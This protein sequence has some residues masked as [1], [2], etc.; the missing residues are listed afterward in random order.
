MAKLT[1]QE[2]PLEDERYV[3]FCTEMNLDRVVTQAQSTLKNMKKAINQLE[4]AERALQLS[5]AQTATVRLPTLEMKQFS[6]KRLEWTEFWEAFSLSVDSRADLTPIQ[7][8]TYLRSYVSGEAKTLIAGLSLE[9]HNY[10]LAVDLLKQEYGDKEAIAARSNGRATRYPLIWKPLEKKLTKQILREISKAE[11]KAAT[12]NTTKLRLELGK[13][14]REEEKLERKILEEH[15][16]KPSGSQHNSRHQSRQHQQSQQLANEPTM[17]YA[18]IVQ[19]EKPKV[20]PIFGCCFCDLMHYPD[21]CT[22]YPTVKLRQQ[23]LLDLKRCVKCT[24]RNHL[25]QDCRRRLSCWHCSG[26]HTRALCPREFG[27]PNGDNS[28]KKHRRRGQ[29]KSFNQQQHSTNAVHQEASSPKV[30]NFTPMPETQAITPAT[31]A[32]ATP[33]RQPGA[34]SIMAPPPV[35]GSQTLFMSAEVPVFSLV[36]PNKLVTAV[37]LFNCCSHDTFASTGIKEEANLTSIGSTSFNLMKFGSTEGTP[38]NSSRLRF[39]MV[40]KNGERMLIE[41]TQMDMLTVETT[42]ALLTEADLQAMGQFEF[43]IQSTRPD[44]RIGMDQFHLFQVSQGVPLPSGFFL[45][46][47]RVGPLI[48]GKGVMR[49][50]ICQTSTVYTMTVLHKDQDA[51]TVPTQELLLMTILHWRREKNITVKNGRYQVSFPWSGDACELPTNCGLALGRLK[52][53]AV[54]TSKLRIVYDGSAKLN[55]QAKSLNSCLYRGPVL[56]SDLAG[57][58]LRFRMLSIVITADIEKAFLQLGIRKAD[59]NVTASSGFE[60]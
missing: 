36:E 41:A 54:I 3:T 24:Y 56:T 43:P 19:G 44:I 14:I 28:K 52:S 35:A 4:A 22:K 55:K 31:A 11:A 6:G 47:S 40:M 48:S 26:Q 7:K 30:Q 42:M 1:G 18:A 38:V 13:I 8:L 37:I 20:A 23:R 34:Y 5:A 46:S 29:Q 49:S 17:A 53:V 16:P 9:A 51:D 58:L 25:E 57:M 50:P 27:Q 60:M 12:W 33:V 59:R 15:K 32:N 39:G 2:R 45:S 21:E 10:K